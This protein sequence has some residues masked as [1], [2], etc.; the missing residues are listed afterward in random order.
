MILRRVVPDAD[1][2]IDLDASDAR[3][4]I[5]ELYHPTLPDWIRLNL[6]GTLTGGA[7][8]PDGTSESITNPVDR[9]IL[10]VIRSLSDVV[11]VGAASVRAEGYFVPKRA[12]LAVVTGTGELAG[13]H[14]TSG[15][16]R[17]PL[18]ILCPPDAADRARG[19]V[20]DPDARIL[21]VP[22][23]NGRIASRDIVAALRAEGFRSIVAEGGPDLA[24]RLVRDGVV[25]ELC[26][27]TS[28]QL[29]PAVVPLFADTGRPPIRLRLDQ[30]LVDDSG[31]TYVKWAFARRSNEAT[32][33]D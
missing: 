27:T 30:L 28:P 5:A 32:A 13:H 15:T 1:V 6:I 21:V 18:I 25:D 29:G 24:T 33:A 14:I 11:L 22:A 12:A 8:G 19:S 10:G 26:L 23:V 17:G 20:G 4:R 2:S 7:T 31:T 3:D 16:G 9:I